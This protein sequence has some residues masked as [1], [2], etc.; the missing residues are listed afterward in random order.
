MIAAAAFE[1]EYTGR[2]SHAGFF[3][4]LGVNAADAMTV[5]Q[6]A[7]GLLRQHIRTTDR[8]LASSRTAATR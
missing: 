2:E 8:V 6:V 1:V 3:P 4:E 7:M 5:A